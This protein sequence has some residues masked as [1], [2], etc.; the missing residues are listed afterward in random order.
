MN[1]YDEKE[2]IKQ[3]Q[4]YLYY[5][6]LKNKALPSIAADGIYG[7]ETRDAVI[8]YQKM[9]GLPVTGVADPATIKAIVGVTFVVSDGENTA[10]G[11]FWLPDLKVGDRGDEVRL[12]QTAL[13]I[14]GYDCGAADGIFGAKTQAALNKFK[15]DRGM[16]P[17]GTA[18]REVWEKVLGVN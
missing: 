4:T 8:A 15:E 17:D 14:R 2:Y 5:L 3:L 11:T 16:D 10:V 13:R 12:L 9:R 6:S 7:D 18:D 1:G